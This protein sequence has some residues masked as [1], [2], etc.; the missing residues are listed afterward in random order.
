MSAPASGLSALAAGVRPAGRYGIFGLLLVLLAV[1]ATVEEFRTAVNL[2]NVLKQSA[3]LGILALGQSFVVAGGM[4]DLSVGQL[5]GLVVVVTCDLMQ[6]ESAMTVP[7]VLLALALGAAVGLINGTLNNRL[8]VHPLILTFGML[9]ILQGMIFVYTDQSVGSV[10]P[11]FRRLADG[12]VAGVPFAALLL[13]AAGLGAAFLLHRTRF[14]HHLL[15]LGGSEE[16]ARRAGID[17][18][19]VKLLAFVLSGLSAGVAGILLAG[20][21]GTG[22]PNAGAGF[23]LDAIVAVVLGGTPLAGGRGTIAG[24]LAAVL[25]LGIASNLLN[26][27]EVS[28]FVQMLIKGLIVIL[29]ILLNQPARGRA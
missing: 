5:A 13:A 14:G 8:R 27:L 11:G 15:A 1:G 19:R 25:V 22:Y 4:I 12:S 10:S 18:G 7:A 28:A 9:S 6:G 20:R 2:A 23:E 16:N 3:A 26:L 29:A 24:T 21:L 17:T